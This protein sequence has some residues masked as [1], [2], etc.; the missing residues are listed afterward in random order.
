MKRNCELQ[1]YDDSPAKSRKKGRNG[2]SFNLHAGLFRM[3]GVD[4]TPIDGIDMITVVMSEAW[5]EMS[6][7]AAVKHFTSWLGLCPGTRI[8]GGKRMSGKT[9][10]CANR[11]AQALRMGAAARAAATPRWAPTI[12]ACAHAWTNPKP[13]RPP[14]ISWRARST[15]C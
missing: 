15:C 1:V 2:P 8:A 11:V 9:T 7:F 12:A 5:P 4:L 3:C 6:R 10:R 13:S 14:R